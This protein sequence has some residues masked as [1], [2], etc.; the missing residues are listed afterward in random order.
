[1]KMDVKKEELY[2]AIQNNP[3]HIVNNIFMQHSVN[4]IEYLKKELKMTVQNKKFH[5]WIDLLFV[6]K[7]RKKLWNSWQVN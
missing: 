1:M 6:F 5:S 2:K 4:E 3:K 7:S